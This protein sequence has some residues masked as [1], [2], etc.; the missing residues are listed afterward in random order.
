MRIAD[1]INI[2][3]LRA[4]AC[5]RLPRVAFDYLDG[6]AE[7]E[8]TLARNR[9][10]FRR[11]AFVPRILSG[12]A[13]RDL[14]VTLFGQAQKAPWVVGP[15]GLNGI[16]WHGADLAL[17]R[18]A[19]RA[20]AVYAHATAANVALED[21]ARSANGV[22]WFQLYPW[23]DRDVWA[24][25]VERAQH[26]GYR[27]L[28]VTVDS[29]LGG[30]RERDR[31]NHFAH[32]VR[33]TPRVL[34]DGLMHP[35]WLAGV[36]LRRGM[37]R[38]ENMAEFA[39]PGA[40]A[41]ELA[42][43]IRTMRNPDFSWDD[44]GWIRARWRG[45]FLVK[46]VLSPADAHRAAGMGADGIVVSNHGGRQLDGGIATLDALPPIVDAVGGEM[47][48][49]IDSG[50]RRGSDV[51]KALALG[52]KAV[53]LGRAPL[54]GVAAAG[55][56]GVERALEIL[57]EETLRVLALLGCPNLQSLSRECLR[58]TDVTPISSIDS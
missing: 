44:L 36:W 2:A 45:P 42:D 58:A 50:F 26:A 25:L 7:D 23:G 19:E 47:T 56:A 1:S 27:A 17:A 37:P 30:N 33:Y 10:A 6:G 57:R 3:D 29:L 41:A 21:V 48:V 53:V 35:R 55:E 31:R 20:G 49:L 43:Y 9:A 40:T 46:G 34:L 32:H 18:A 22:N 14:S 4:M 28:I 38:F 11:Y 12:A 16:F 52:A 54:Y 24:R 39:R 13:P 51:V 8:V 15:T 5:R